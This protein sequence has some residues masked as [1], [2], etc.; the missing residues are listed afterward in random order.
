MP[1]MERWGV[2]A[3]STATPNSPHDGE[4]LPD[5]WQWTH[6]WRDPRTKTLQ[7]RQVDY[8]LSRGW[9]AHTEVCYPWGANFDHQ[10]LVLRIPEQEG[11]LLQFQSN[12]FSN[13]GWC[14][15]YLLEAKQVVSKLK[16]F[17]RGGAGCG[18]FQKGL[19]FTGAAS[20]VDEPPI[21][22][23]SFPNSRAA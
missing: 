7:R 11:H 1:F 12:G 17:V 3:S 2:L 20:S 9:E 13:K 8:M 16:Q 15:R 19:R 23:R 10:P 21:L 5:P 14:P 18:V 6:S 4:S 22:A